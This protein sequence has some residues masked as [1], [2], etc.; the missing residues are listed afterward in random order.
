[1]QKTRR[2]R[3]QIS[4]TGLNAECAKEDPE[5]FTVKPFRRGERPGKC[6]REKK[7]EVVGDRG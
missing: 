5:N 4:R 3:I 2:T 1:M 7:D 6:R